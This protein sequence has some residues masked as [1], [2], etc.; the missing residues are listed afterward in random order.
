MG[1]QKTNNVYDTIKIPNGLTRL[2]DKIIIESRGNF[3]SRT[4]VIKYVVRKYTDELENK[5]RD[6]L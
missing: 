5:K 1:R 6:E 2:I 4:D 3:T